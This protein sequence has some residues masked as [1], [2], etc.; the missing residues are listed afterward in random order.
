MLLTAKNLTVSYGA[1]VALHEV[2]VEIQPGE[3]VALIGANGAGKTTLLRTISGLLKPSGGTITWLPPIEGDDKT[4]EYQVVTRDLVGMRP[5]EIV[6]LGISHVPEEQRRVV[7]C[8]DERPAVPREHQ[9]VRLAT[10]PRQPPQFPP[11]FHVPQA[12]RAVVLT[13]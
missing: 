8:R 4:L 7:P 6:R 12:N 9:R 3:I 1:I 5:D 11:C 10:V 13:R 2:S